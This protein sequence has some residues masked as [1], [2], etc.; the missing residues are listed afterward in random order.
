MSDMAAMYLCQH[1]I[2]ATSI[3]GDR[4]QHLREQ[5]LSD[6]RNH[7]V[8][9]LCATDVCAR[10]IDVKQLD[11]VINME[12]PTDAITYV[13]R[14]GRTGR[15]TNGWSTTFVEGG[16]YLLNEIADMIRESNEEVPESL[17]AAISGGGTTS[18]NNVP[19]TGQRGIPAA[20]DDN[21]DW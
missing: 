16:E 15:I 21:D 2:P 14:I 18:A 9:V 6:F 13:H 5:A 4:G 12:L 1:G 7:K 8:S 11:H 10:G 3:N 20:A 19:V 17:K